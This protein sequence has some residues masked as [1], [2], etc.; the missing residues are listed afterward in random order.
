VLLLNEDRRCVGENL[1][2]LAG[3]ASRVDLAV[4]YLTDASVLA[5]W[6]TG[7]RIVNALV[8]LTPPTSSSALRDATRIR[9]PNLDLRFLG[10]GFHSKLFIFYS[11]GVPFAA[12][13]GSSNLTSGGLKGNIETNVTVEDKAALRQLVEFF[14][15]LWRTAPT[16][17]PDDIEK[18]ASY[19]KRMP[20]LPRIRTRA[21]G[22]RVPRPSRPCKQARDYRAF[23]RCVDE[24]K[25]LV[26]R[27][28]SSAWPRLEVYTSIDHFW[29]WLK[30]EWDRRGIRRMKADEQY[31]QQRIPGLFRSYVADTNSENA[32]F[33]RTTLDEIRYSQQLCRP[34]RLQVLTPKEARDIYTSVYAG[35]NVAGR[36]D[37]DRFFTRDNSIDKI[38]RSLYHL[39]WDDDE[40]IAWRLH[41]LLAWGTPHRL[42]WMGKSTTLDLLG[43]VRP[44][45]Y[46]P[47]NDKAYFG[48][49]LL[50]Y[51]FR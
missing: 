18:L 11:G 36:F 13:V 33:Q 44:D 4:A 2:R 10:P 40:D 32:D 43:W 51:R 46:P 39:L 12:S 9:R 20:R 17:E 7:R 23:W 22:E 6:T 21:D 48:A 25:R 5:R 41:D 42:E 30:N 45:K 15:G 26:S 1:N 31:R 50:G 19:E 8:A 28:A 37:T 34:K 14:G 27:Q 29:Y 24:V 16:V 47:G 38:R 35:A 49:E 3:R